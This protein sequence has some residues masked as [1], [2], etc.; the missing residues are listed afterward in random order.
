MYPVS[1]KPWDP[2]SRVLV[3]AIGSSPRRHTPTPRFAL[4]RQLIL[5]GFQL[6]WRP[7]M[8]PPC[9]QLRQL[10][11]SWWILPR[12]H[13]QVGRFWSR[14]P[15]AT[16]DVLLCLRPRTK[17]GSSSLEFGQHKW[18][19]ANRRAPIAWLRST[20]GSDFR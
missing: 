15:L 2:A 17:V 20:W 6:I 14:A 12:R 11:P 19:T 4:S 16:L 9:P 18:N 1:S 8:R 7:S 10:G 13:S 3:A 5:S